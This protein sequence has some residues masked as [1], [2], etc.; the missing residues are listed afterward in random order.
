[1]ID[2]VNLSRPSRLRRGG[3]ELDACE[4]YCDSVPLLKSSR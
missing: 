1:M 4:Q 3:S 2:L